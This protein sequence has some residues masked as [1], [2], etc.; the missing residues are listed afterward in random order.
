MA[1]APR[2]PRAYE[3]R[4]RGH[5]RAHRFEPGGGYPEKGASPAASA[6]E[7][8]ELGCQNPAM[9]MADA[10]LDVAVRQVVTGALSFNGQ[11]CTGLNF[12]FIHAS[13]FEGLDAQR[14][15][16]RCRQLSADPVHR[17]IS[18]RHTAVGDFADFQGACDEILG[19]VGEKRATQKIGKSAI[20]VLRVGLKRVRLRRC[21]FVTYRTGYLLTR[22]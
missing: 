19:S 10:D 15:L 22:V 20:G 3:K 21:S 1:A 9:V 2:L 18:R 6:A 13:H 11:R 14:G 16:A 12:T 17:L 7:H 4:Q 8:L 5:P